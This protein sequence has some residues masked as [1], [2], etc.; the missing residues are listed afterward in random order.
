MPFTFENRALDRGAVLHT[1][2]HVGDQLTGD[3]IADQAGRSPRRTRRALRTLH[4]LSM[5]RPVQDGAAWEITPRGR[6]VAASLSL[7]VV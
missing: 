6:E 2:L 1:L 5:V 4:Q 7:T 3:V